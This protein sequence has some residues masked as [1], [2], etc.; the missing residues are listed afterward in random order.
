[1]WPFTCD[2][3]NTASS[4]VIPDINRRPRNSST[5]ARGGKGRKVFPPRLNPD[6][7]FSRPKS[8]AM[9]PNLPVMNETIAVNSSNG[10]LVHCCRAMYQRFISDRKTR[11]FGTRREIGKKIPRRSDGRV[12]S[13]PENYGKPGIYLRGI[14]QCEFHCYSRD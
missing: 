1:M 13:L 2:K 9:R 6:G 11:I 7:D 12:L 14:M 5:S 4:I 3:L 8:A 10:Q